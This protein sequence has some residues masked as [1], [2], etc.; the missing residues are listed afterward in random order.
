MFYTNRGVAR[1]ARR[2]AAGA[3]RAARLS[4]SAG[5]LARSAALPT[6]SNQRGVA[7][8]AGTAA[9]ACTRFLASPACTT[10]PN[11]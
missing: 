9:V 11:D 3:Q 2:A 1:V 10:L 7:R 4:T 6:S 8:P 5:V